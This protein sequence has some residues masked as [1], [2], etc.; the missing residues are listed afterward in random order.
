MNY[1]FKLAEPNSPEFELQGPNFWGQYKLYMNGLL[2]EGIGRWRK[3]DVRFPDG[4]IRKVHLGMPAIFF[5]PPQ[6][7]INNKAT[8]VGELTKFHRYLGYLPAIV[9]FFYFWFTLK[10]PNHALFIF[11]S[12]TISGA[13]SSVYWYYLDKIFAVERGQ[14]NRAALA[15]GLL[16][17]ICVV[18]LTIFGFL[19]NSIWHS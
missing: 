15:M 7:I 11:I 12:A 5:G 8:F 13:T 18:P 14:L 16:I 6:L 9:L 1:K 3:K 17:L 10:Y 4:S 2:I 19:A